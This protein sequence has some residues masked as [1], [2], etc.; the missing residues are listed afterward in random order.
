M[1]KKALF[2]FCV[3]TRACVRA[4]MSASECFKK[5]P[6]KMSSIRLL[7]REY[8]TL[9]TKIAEIQCKTMLKK[10]IMLVRARALRTRQY[11]VYQ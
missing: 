4:R 1:E 11:K 2:P 3:L 6:Y 8:P 9:A 10:Q 5:F 7:D